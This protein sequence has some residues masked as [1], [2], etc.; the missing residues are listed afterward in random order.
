MDS[1]VSLPGA[2]P[3]VPANWDDAEPRT[4]G[5]YRVLRR[6][7]DGGMSTVY[8]GYDPQERR[9]VALKV[10]A[11]HLHDDRASTGRFRRE[12]KL[13]QTLQCPHVVRTLDADRDPA[14]GRSFLVSN[15]LTARAVSSCSTAPGR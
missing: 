14:T 4:F 15:T 3:R 8:L 9:P 13:G 6:L 2:A 7:G 5:R 1:A 11:E 10:L 12:A